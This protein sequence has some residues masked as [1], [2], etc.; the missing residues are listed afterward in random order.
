MAGASGDG[1]DLSP[2]IR[3]NF[4]PKKKWADA[5]R[6]IAAT[7]KFQRAGSASGR[8]VLDSD[9]DSDGFTTAESDEEEATASTTGATVESNAPSGAPSKSTTLTSLVGSLKAMTT[10]TAEAE[11]VKA[12]A[13]K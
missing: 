7:R 13:A 12:P 1:T 10:R 4:N 8:N 5:M 9:S 11:E 3:E 6:V 2:N